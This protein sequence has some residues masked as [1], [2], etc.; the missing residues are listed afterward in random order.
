MKIQALGGCCPKTTQNYLNA[1]EAAEKLGQGITVDHVKDMN[2]IIA[3]GVMSTPALAIDGKVVAAG[4][5]L[6]PKQIIDLVQQ[7]QKGVK[8]DECA[9][10]CCDGKK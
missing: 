6:S 4:R 7:A 1:V 10:G 8:K 3:M 9:P 5:V 2:Q